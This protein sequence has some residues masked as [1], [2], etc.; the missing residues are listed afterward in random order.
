M[1]RIGLSALEQG[2]VDTTACVSADDPL[3]KG[4]D[5]SL[6][7]P[8]RVSGQLCAAGPGSYYWRGKLQTAMDATCR[9]CLAPASVRLEVPVN[10]LFTEDEQADD[11]SVY[12][13][14]R[15]ATMLDL[16]G[17]VREELMLGVPKYVVCR[18][19]CA[20]LCPRCGE[21]LNEGPRPHQCPSS[22][23]DPRWAALETLKKRAT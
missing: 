10:I 19:D 3:L 2:P 5:F 21:N 6:S 8:V 4:M 11:L 16:G 1:L 22:S 18:E 13:I 9:R 23:A 15:H 20:G 17:P 7:E 14:P 12:P